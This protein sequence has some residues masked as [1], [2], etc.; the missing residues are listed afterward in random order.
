M[1]PWPGEAFHCVH[2]SN[3]TSNAFL[4]LETFCPAFP[5]SSFGRVVE[6]TEVKYSVVEEP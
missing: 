5:P 1:S 3:D 2:T 6:L 4:A